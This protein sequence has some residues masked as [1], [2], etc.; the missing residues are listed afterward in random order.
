[1][2]D[3]VD[4]CE[5]GVVFLLYGSCNIYFFDG[6]GF[7]I[8]S[9]NQVYENN[10]NILMVDMDIDVESDFS[11]LCMQLLQWSRGIDLCDF[12]GDGDLIEVCL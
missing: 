2:L 8:Q 6:L 1:M 12:D 10:L 3:G 11:G 9:S 4:V 7:I 5:G